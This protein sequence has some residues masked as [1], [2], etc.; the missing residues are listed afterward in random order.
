MFEFIWW[1]LG[2][3]DIDPEV[4]MRML[5]PELDKIFKYFNNLKTIQPA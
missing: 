4:E 3:R 2:Y 1:L 5:H